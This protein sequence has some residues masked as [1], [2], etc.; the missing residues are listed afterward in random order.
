[1]HS[2]A[3]GLSPIRFAGSV[4]NTAIGQLAIAIGH[5][6][7]S[8]AV[9]GGA[10]TLAIGLLEVIG[11]FADDAPEVVL[12]LADEPLPPPL[13]P[14]YDGLA[15]GLHLVRTPGP[16]DVV[17]VGPSARGDRDL[18][19]ARVPAAIAGNPCIAAFRLAH[20][21]REGMF[22]LVA[23]EPTVGDNSRSVMCVDLQPSRG[24]S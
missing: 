7:R 11:L 24:A 12:V 5:R 1:M 10:H 15:V 17:L 14:S 4:H 21:I 16:D 3:G 13:S 23:L 19:N 22:G 8:S 2:E 9:S 20:A 18:V 6:G